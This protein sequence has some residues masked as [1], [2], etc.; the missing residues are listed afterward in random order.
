VTIYVLESEMIE[1]KNFDDSFFKINLKTIIT[2]DEMSGA[3]RS[4][5]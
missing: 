3:S 2:N 4:K 5:N 1:K